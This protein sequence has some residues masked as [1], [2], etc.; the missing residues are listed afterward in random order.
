MKP[1]AIS[2]LVLLCAVKGAVLGAAD[3]VT[4]NRQ[5]APL[6]FRHCSSCHR[7]GEAAPFPL[8]TYDDV[9]SH[10]AQ[11]IAVTRRRYMPPWLPEAGYGDFAGESRLTD[12]Q[13]DSISEWVAQGCPRG[14]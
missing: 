12:S 9:R 6:I 10:A 2:L 14:D 13:L 5:I 8:L 1:P 7:P 3:R 4:F 11:I